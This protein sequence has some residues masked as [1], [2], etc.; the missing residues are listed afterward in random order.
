MNTPPDDIDARLARREPLFR[1]N[2]AVDLL[3][4]P[5]EIDRIVLARVRAA[6]RD[7]SSDEASRPAFFTLNQW[8]MP[9]G[10]AATVVFALAVIVRMDP[11]A[12]APAARVVAET[13]LRRD[14]RDASTAAATPAPA[15]DAPMAQ[16]IAAKPTVASRRAKG[17]NQD[18]IVA[19]TAR[20][21]AREAE[22][23]NAAAELPATGRA[24]RPATAAAP[25]PPPAAAVLADASE[26]RMTK[27]AGGSG[28]NLPS[29]QASALRSEAVDIQ[30]SPE[31]WYRK[32]VELRSKG[33]RLAA[34][35]E[36]RALKA[37]YPDFEAPPRTTA[38]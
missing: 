3:E 8:V 34:E 37:R 9:L 16:S 18:R 2:T 30:A 25:A 15:A 4:P 35:R 13:D 14:A 24:Q 38:Q 32:I 5:V 7:S 36:W 10:L 17:A 33:Q 31:L 29:S 19:Q 20:E 12:G 1:R 22:I 23:D 6:L 26:D 27:A 28:L 11:D 21:V